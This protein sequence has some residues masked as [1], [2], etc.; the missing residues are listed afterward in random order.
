VRPQ[1]VIVNY[2]TWE[3][4]GCPNTTAALD[5][6]GGLLQITN[7]PRRAQQGARLSPSAD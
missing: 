1:A 5:E 3:A 6:S 4:G 2:Q 7:T